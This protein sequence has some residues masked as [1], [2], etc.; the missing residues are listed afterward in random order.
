ML[1]ERTRYD[2]A[3]A[4]PRIF[5]RW[6]EAHAFDA[7]PDAPGDPY[8]ITVP[9][10]NVTGSLH[11]GHALNG[12]VQDALIRLKR[13]QGRNVAVAGRH[14]PRRHRHADG[15]RAAAGAHRA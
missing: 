1:D 12:S 2:A 15:G 13:M 14:R 6:T 11:M 7:E 5:T 3:T 8:C 4:E 10:P 9:P